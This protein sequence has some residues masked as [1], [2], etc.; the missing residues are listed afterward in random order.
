MKLPSD[1]LQPAGQL[2]YA[3]FLPYSPSLFVTARH[4]GMSQKIG[5]NKM[6]ALTKISPVLPKFSSCSAQTGQNRVT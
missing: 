4:E 6:S 3:D 2:L 1:W 5:V